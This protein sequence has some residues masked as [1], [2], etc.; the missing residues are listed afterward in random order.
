[1]AEMQVGATEP[2]DLVHTDRAAEPQSVKHTPTHSG[3]THA[4]GTR[5]PPV[6]ANTLVL[7]LQADIFKRS[8]MEECETVCVA[9]RSCSSLHSEVKSS[10]EELSAVQLHEDKQNDC[11]HAIIHVFHNS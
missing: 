5:E 3:H 1:M 2:P 10:H 11:L 8:T 6:T 4:A 7:Q 9:F